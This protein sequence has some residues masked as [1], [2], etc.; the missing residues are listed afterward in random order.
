MSIIID[1]SIVNIN[2]R[3]LSLFNANRNTLEQNSSDVING[4]RDAAKGAFSKL[5]VPSRKVE[6]YKYS[7][8]TVSF[9][10]TWNIDFQKPSDSVNNHDLFHCSVPELDVCTVVLVNGWYMFANA[11][12]ED[13]IVGSL[14]EISKTNPELVQKY[15]GKQAPVTEDGMVALNTMFA[16]DGL[17]LHVKKGAIIEKPIHVINIL[18]GAKDRLSF[19]RNLIVLDESS[20]A[21]V[22]FCD[23]TLNTSKFAANG[24]T[25]VFAAENALFEYY[26]VQSQHNLTTQIHGVYVNQKRY[27]NVQTSH[28]TLHCGTSRNNVYIRLDDEDCEAHMYGLYLMDKNQHIDNHTFVDHA[29]PNCHSNELFKGVLDDSATGAFTGSIMVRPDAQKTLAYQSNKNI[30]LTQDAKFNTKPQLEIYADDV[31][32]SHGAT[33]GQIDDEALFYMRARG[34]GEQEAQIL[35]MYAFTYEVVEKISI[36]PLQNEIKSLIEKRFRGE[37]S[38]CDSCVMC[39]QTPSV[40]QWV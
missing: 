13:T 26:N 8:L 10:D 36:E 30:L 4:A 12:P 31:K 33:V 28:I 32:C 34:I 40:S 39:S 37:L 27:S 20:S 18:T 19:F 25:E 6:S 22:L 11:V 16:Q 35:L 3:F 5:G 23:H 7:D 2:E 38:K 17:F 9:N 1:Q 24:V 15:Y 29:Y 14:S 21:K